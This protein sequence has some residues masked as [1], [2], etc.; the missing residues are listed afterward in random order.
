MYCH[1]TDR[2]LILSSEDRVRSKPTSYSP[3]TCHTQAFCRPL[4]PAV[5]LRC[6][7]NN[8]PLLI[9]ECGFLALLSD[10]FPQDQQQDESFCTETITITNKFISFFFASCGAFLLFRLNER[11]AMLHCHLNH[12]KWYHKIIRMMNNNIFW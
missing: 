11:L 1:L 2:Y 10:L 4:L 12:A 7:N 6:E 5:L 9:T 3:V 8:F